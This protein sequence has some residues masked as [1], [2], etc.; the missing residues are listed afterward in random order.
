MFKKISKLFFAASSLAIVM[1][2]CK[3]EVNEELVLP[4]SEVKFA[5]SDTG[6]KTAP[7]VYYVENTPT[8]SVKIPVGFTTVADKDRTINIAYTSPTGAALGTQFT[9]PTSVVIPAGQA[10]D[11]ITLRGLFAG[12]PNN[13]VDTV[14]ITLTSPDA[15]SA[16]FAATYHLV[17]RPFCVVNLTT[18]AGTYADTREYSSS[19][20]LSWGPYT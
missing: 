6:T 8:S 7:K 5:T 1:V 14:R 4:R 13:R 12:F 11:T 16:T 10:S 17:L 2:A 15:P 9:A 20:A 19:G 3:K 18:L